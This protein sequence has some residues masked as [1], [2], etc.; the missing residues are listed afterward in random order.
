MLIVVEKKIIP[1][2]PLHF[3]LLFSLVNH[4]GQGSSDH[5]FQV[6]I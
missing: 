2:L 3:F 4:F 6:N 1:A 5:D